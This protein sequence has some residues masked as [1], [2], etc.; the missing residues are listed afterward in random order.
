MF[1]H[2]PHGHTEVRVDARDPRKFGPR[3]A[4]DIIRR[5]REKRS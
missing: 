1:V 5:T 4:L 3:A 2:L